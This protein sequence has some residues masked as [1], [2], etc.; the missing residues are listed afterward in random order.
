SPFGTRPELRISDPLLMAQGGHTVDVRARLNG[1]VAA[2]SEAVTLDTDIDIEPPAIET[3]TSSAGVQ[4][5]AE[6][7]NPSEVRWRGPD[8]QW[9]PWS[10]STAIDAQKL[11][12]GPRVVVA[13][14][15][16]HAI[17]LRSFKEVVVD[18]SSTPV[19]PGCA[20]GGAG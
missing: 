6:D 13:V 15:A 12:L 19:T 7:F 8:G 11:P 16:R 3:N 20:A 1:E 17:G 4:I 2:V 14:E 9:S 10:A 5:S 18:T